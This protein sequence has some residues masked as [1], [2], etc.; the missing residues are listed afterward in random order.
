M[1]LVKAR[2]LYFYSLSL[3][4]SQSPL[5]SKAKAA[6]TTCLSAR[7]PRVASLL[8]SNVVALLQLR[9]YSYTP[10]KGTGGSSID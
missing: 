3:S 1:Q 5:L 4:L 8:C 2:L 6:A 7:Y 9:S 10:I